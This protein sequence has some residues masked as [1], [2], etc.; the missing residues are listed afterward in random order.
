MSDLNLI[1]AMGMPHDLAA[2]IADLEPIRQKGAVEG[3]HNAGVGGRQRCSDFIHAGRS[4]WTRRLRCQI[5]IRRLIGAAAPW[6]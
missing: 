2:A 1:R 5:T 6:L 3:W 4:D